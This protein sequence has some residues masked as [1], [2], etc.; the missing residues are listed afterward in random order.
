[1]IAATIA[2]VAIVSV[3]TAANAST[4]YPPNGSCTTSPAA[5]TPGSTSTF[6]CRAGTFSANESVTIT[7]TGADG[8]DA[9]VGMVRFASTASGAARSESD[10]SLAGVRITFPATARG[11]YNIAALSATSAGSTGSVTVTSPDG[12][13]PA[14][15]LDSSTMTGLW[16][17]GGLLVVAGIAVGAVA[18]IR[19]R[20]DSR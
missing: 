7:V 14:T 12:S 10:G 17:G 16:I 2:A 20:Q 13:L 19:R 1:M 6:A 3:P 15:G 11:T 9:R 5:V 18:V 4:I 8:A